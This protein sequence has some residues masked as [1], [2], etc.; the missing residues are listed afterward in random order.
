MQGCVRAG[1][2]HPA[3]G[4]LGRGAAAGRDTPPAAPLTFAH[5]PSFT[6]TPG[7][8]HLRSH[9]GLPSPTLGR[10]APSA[11]LPALL[12][13]HCTTRDGFVSPYLAHLSAFILINKM[14]CFK[15]NMA[16]W[17]EKFKTVKKYLI[18]NFFTV[19]PL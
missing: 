17:V 15:L 10:N 14:L 1:W 6:H 16:K 5:V 11:S 9:S 3:G 8:A 13:P 7:T 18:L 4:M 2:L 19:S 12:P